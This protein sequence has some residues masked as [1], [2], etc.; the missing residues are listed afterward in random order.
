ML[1][2]RPERPDQPEV[3]ALLEQ[4]DAYLASLYP[5]EANHILDVQALL[6]PDVYF[7]VARRA[8]RLVGIGAFRR[9]PGETATAGEPYGEIKR[10]FVPPAERGQRI[11]EKLLNSLE[12]RLRTESYRWALL[13]T[14][15]D[16]HEAIRLYE[17]CGYVRR[18]AFAGYPD[19]GLSAFYAKAL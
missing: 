18:G 5:P 12:D 17:R 7:Q 15:V 11:A 6:A 14:G 4:L 9:M 2:I 10:M 8:G 16:Q 19:N 1:T 3:A 13:E